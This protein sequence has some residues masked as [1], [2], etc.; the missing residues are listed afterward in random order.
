MQ[1]YSEMEIQEI[2]L[3]SEKQAAYDAVCPAMSRADRR[4]AKGRMLVAQGEAAALRA[5]NA[6]LKSELGMK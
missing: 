2:N 5:E 4:T 6:F 3:R 1:Q